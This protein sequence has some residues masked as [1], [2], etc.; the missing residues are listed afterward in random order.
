MH[1]HDR[2]SRGRRRHLRGIRALLRDRRGVRVAPANARTN[3]ADI[4]DPQGQIVELDT[5]VELILYLPILAEDRRIRQLTAAV[6]FQPG[7]VVHLGQVGPEAQLEG[8]VLRR[9]ALRERLGS[10]QPAPIGGRRARLLSVLGQ[11]GASSKEERGGSEDGSGRANEGAHRL[12]RVAR[13]TR[14]RR[15]RRATSPKAISP[16]LMS[17]AN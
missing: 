13:A 5:E 17:A 16:P 11:R 6:R 12:P 4:G 7:L 3:D 2:E 8:E 10:I 9:A 14:G 15:W 1:W